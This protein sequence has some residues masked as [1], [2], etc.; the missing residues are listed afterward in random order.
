MDSLQQE[1]PKVA[2]SS[3]SGFD[4]GEV[5]A[6]AGG[7][8]G[9]GITQNGKEQRGRL[10]PAMNGYLLTSTPVKLDSIL[11][12]NIVGRINIIWMIPLN[13]NVS[14]SAFKKE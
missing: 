7:G 8:G 10:L 14:A 4:L 13:P 11:W 9:F 1:T 3:K 5:P 6:N 12:N 2:S